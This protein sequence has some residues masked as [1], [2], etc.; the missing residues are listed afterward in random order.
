MHTTVWILLRFFRQ[1]IFVFL[2]RETI[3]TV[4]RV[5]HY[6]IMSIG[7]I[8]KISTILLFYYHYY[9]THTGLSP[10]PRSF[11]YGTHTYA[12]AHTHHPYGGH[13]CSSS[14]AARIRRSDALLVHV[15]LGSTVLL[16]RSS[17]RVYTLSRF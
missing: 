11:P 10:S 17:R 4:A 8:I 15:N 14:A 6:N 5:T 9:H 7:V 13:R 3:Y 2:H 12:Y 1:E 16:I